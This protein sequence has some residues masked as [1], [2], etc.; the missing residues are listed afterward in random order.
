[1]PDVREFA[2][3]I[4][5]LKMTKDFSELKNIGSRLEVRHVHAKVSISRGKHI[6]ILLPNLPTMKEL[7]ALQDKDMGLGLGK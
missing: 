5:K 7:T 2:A 4:I 1:M 3:L 6:G